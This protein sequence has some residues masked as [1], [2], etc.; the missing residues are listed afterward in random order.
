MFTEH[1]NGFLGQYN[2]LKELEPMARSS[3]NLQPE[4]FNLL[5]KSI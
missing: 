1:E 4:I 2:L 5:R 3:V